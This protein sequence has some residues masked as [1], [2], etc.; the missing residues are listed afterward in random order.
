[1]ELDT[2]ELLLGQVVAEHLMATLQLQLP[3]QQLSL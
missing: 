1:M 3:T 2:Q